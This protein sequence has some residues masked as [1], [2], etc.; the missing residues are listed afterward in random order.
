MAISYRVV[1]I[2]EAAN[3][4]EREEM[5]NGGQTGD[6]TEKKEKRVF[7][8]KRESLESQSPTSIRGFCLPVGPECQ[9]VLSNCLCQRQAM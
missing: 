6:G 3:T 1:S 2:C 9:L 4:R 8:E 5:R 7:E